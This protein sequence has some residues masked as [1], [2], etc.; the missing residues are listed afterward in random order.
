MIACL[1]IYQQCWIPFHLQF[2]T[3]QFLEYVGLQ[4]QQ[5][6]IMIHELSTMHVGFCIPRHLPSWFYN[7]L[8]VP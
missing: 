3:Q 6:K 5:K 4:K 8:V 7:V 1:C 2:A